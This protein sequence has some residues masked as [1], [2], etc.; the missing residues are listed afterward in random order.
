MKYCHTHGLCTH[1]GTENP[2]WIRMK[3]KTEGRDKI[4]DNK[5][6]IVKALS[7]QGERNHKDCF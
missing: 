7:T 1:A 3:G 6:N 2:T 5:V 4:N